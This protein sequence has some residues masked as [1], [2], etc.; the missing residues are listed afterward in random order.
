MTKCLLKLE[1]SKGVP[2]LWYDTSKNTYDS[3]GWGIILLILVGE[4]ARPVRKFWTKQNP[5]Q[6]E[7]WFTIRLPFIILPYISIAIWRFGF[8]LGGKAFTVD[9]D[10][11]WAK[12][13]EYGKRMLTLS[14]TIRRTRDV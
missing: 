4:F 9:A 2:A 6:D 13:E 7:A 5:W 3:K 8:Y 1:L 10:E 11:P 14:A 12:P